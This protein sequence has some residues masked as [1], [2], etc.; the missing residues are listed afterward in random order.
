MLNPVRI[1]VTLLGVGVLLSACAKGGDAPSAADSAAAAAAA[2]S[3]AAFQALIA[4]ANPDKGQV[5]FLQCRACHSL[6]AGG[7][8]KVGPNLHGVFGR[9]AGLAPG[10]AYSEA[11]TQSDVVWSAETLNQWLARPSDFLPGNRMVFVGIRTPE[12][13]AN[14][15]AYLQRETGP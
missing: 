6:E 3:P 8:N 2:E 11:L 5:L 7:P 12:D 1:A 15:I 4:A 9:K 10:Y 13:R 14:V